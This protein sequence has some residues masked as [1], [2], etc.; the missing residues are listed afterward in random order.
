VS[1]DELN[2]DIVYTFPVTDG[3]KWTVRVQRT[4]AGVANRRP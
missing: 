3:I 2:E 1:L 4:D